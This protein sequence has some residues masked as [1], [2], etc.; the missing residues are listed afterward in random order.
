MS[1]YTY[2]IN[3]IT[4]KPEV[5]FTDPTVTAAD[6]A[7]GDVKSFYGS[8]LQATTVQKTSNTSLAPAAASLAAGAVAPAGGGAGVAPAP[9]S[10]QQLGGA[11]PLTPE[12]ALTHVSLGPPGSTPIGG[13]RSV[14]RASQ[15]A[16]RALMQG[17]L[18]GPT[19]RLPLPAA[20]RVRGRGGI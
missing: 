2:D 16:T 7:S 6:A 15:T 1:G 17:P 3:P 12:Q 20:A 19:G 13:V 5:L 18:L 8:P 11:L 10:A 14:R 4:G 9:P